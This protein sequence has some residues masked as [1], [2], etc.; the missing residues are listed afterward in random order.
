MA[1][2]PTVERL[3]QQYDFP[4]YFYRKMTEMPVNKLD[5]IFMCADGNQHVDYNDL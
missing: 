3:V 4:A 1:D 2:V 5:F